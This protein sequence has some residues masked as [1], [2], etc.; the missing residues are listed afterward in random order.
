M[1]Q[2]FYLDSLLS[3]ESSAPVTFLLGRCNNSRPYVSDDSKRTRAQQ[4]RQ[5]KHQV[6]IYRLGKRAHLTPVLW[7]A[8]TNNCLSCLNSAPC[9]DR[10]LYIN[11]YQT[12]FAIEATPNTAV[13]HHRNARP[14]TFVPSTSPLHSFLTTRIHVLRTLWISIVTNIGCATDVFA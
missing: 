3:C 1:T 2:S 9:K 10:A 5:G 11:S 14:Q 7:S 6:T 4:A 8:A 13:P 12:I